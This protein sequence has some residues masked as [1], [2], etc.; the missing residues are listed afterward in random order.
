MAARNRPRSAMVP[1]PLRSEVTAPRARRLLWSLGTKHSNCARGWRAET[2]IAEMNAT[3]HERARG[4]ER[5][6][7]AAKCERAVLSGWLMLTCADALVARQVAV[8]TR[9]LAREQDVTFWHEL[10]PHDIPGIRPRLLDCT[11]IAD[12][13]VSSCSETCLTRSQS[14]KAP[15]LLSWAKAFHCP[16]ASRGWRCTRRRRWIH[17]TLWTSTR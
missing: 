9:L 5:D 1:S 11:G 15:V 2:G 8:E 16:R 3:Q 13:I 7:L 10:N 14:V 17:K 6:M 4:V 12:G